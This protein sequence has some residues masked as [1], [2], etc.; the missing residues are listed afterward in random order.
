MRSEDTPDRV[1]MSVARSIRRLDQS[2]NVHQVPLKRL[3]G[4]ASLPSVSVNG[5]GTAV[6]DVVV[7]SSPREWVIVVIRGPGRNMLERAR[8]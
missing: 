5:V 6:V 2:R 3:R 8:G 4:H 7:A 1:V